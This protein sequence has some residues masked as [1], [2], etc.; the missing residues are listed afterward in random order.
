MN[1]KWFVSV[2]TGFA[3][4]TPL[5]A[6]EVNA[7]GW[8]RLR[9]VSPDQK[10][11]VYLENGE[12]LKGRIQETTPDALVLVVRSGSTRVDAREIV[13]VAR[14][15]RW[16]TAA[17][18]GGIFGG[19]GAAIGAAKAGY[20]TDRNNPSA[21]DRLGAAALFAGVFGGTAAGIG[22]AVGGEFNLYVAS[23]PKKMAQAKP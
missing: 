5:I 8:D 18:L 16:R 1:W 4:A 13:R 19:I 9:R 3:L 6:A 20:I 14:K 22:A 11:T 21:G 15:S 2:L 12:K 7:A 10:V 23:P 17:W